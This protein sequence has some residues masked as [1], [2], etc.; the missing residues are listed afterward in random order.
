MTKIYSYVLRYDD[1]AAPNPFGGVCTLTICKPKIRKYAEIGDWVIGTG[2]K[3][4]RLSNGSINDFSNHLVYAMKITDRKY[5]KEYDEWCKSNLAIKIPDIKSKDLIKQHGDCI[6]DFSNSISIKNP[7][8][9]RAG[10][11]DERNRYRDTSGKY[12]LMSTHFYYF[13]SKPE[14]IPDYLYNIIKINQNHKMIVDIEIINAFENWIEKYPV[15]IINEP[16]YM[17]DLTKEYNH[18]CDYDLEDEE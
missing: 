18:R 10:V 1:G 13:G 9:V 15:N 16:Q 2:S 5:L 8:K 17:V 12:S 4:S 14:I 11:H 7:V 3:N 6:Y